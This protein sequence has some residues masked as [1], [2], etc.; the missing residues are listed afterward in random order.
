MYYSDTR[1]PGVVYLKIRHSLSHLKDSKHTSSTRWENRIRTLSAPDIL[2]ATTLYCIDGLQ[3]MLFVCV[4][5]GLAYA[6][7]A[8]TVQ[9]E[10][11]LTVHGGGI[12]CQM[13]A[14][15]ELC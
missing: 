14:G 1:K 4:R 9:W 6:G 5:D 12:F 11:A 8:L 2:L 15:G 7:W 3:C 13:F 10:G